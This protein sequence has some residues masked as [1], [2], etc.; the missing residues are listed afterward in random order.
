MKR[1]WLVYVG[2]GIVAALGIGAAR[3]IN[4]ANAPGTTS[5]LTG[6][7]PTNP[8]NLLTAVGKMGPV[9]TLEAVVNPAAQL[10]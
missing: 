10:P 9:S 8:G 5:A 3:A 7:S 2:G 6:M 4:A 1:H